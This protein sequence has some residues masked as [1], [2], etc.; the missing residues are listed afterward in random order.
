VLISVHGLRLN[1][2][3]DIANHHRFNNQN[4][5]NQ[6]LHESCLQ[7][8]RRSR[9]LG[10]SVADLRVPTIV[11]GATESQTHHG[12]AFVASMRPRLAERG[13]STK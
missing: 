5:S 2:Q 12:D 9:W 3:S 4:S 13:M 1:Q 6:Q 8:H 10:T 11:R 7:L